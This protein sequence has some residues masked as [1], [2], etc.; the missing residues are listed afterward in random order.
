MTA[1]GLWSTHGLARA[2]AGRVPAHRLHGRT[3]AATILTAGQRPSPA[4]LPARASWRRCSCG[5][6]GRKPAASR[7]RCRDT[8]R[9]RARTPFPTAPCGSS[10]A[11]LPPT[12]A[13]APRCRNPTRA[14]SCSHHRRR[15]TGRIDGLPVCQCG[16]RCGDGVVRDPRGDATSAD[17]SLRLID[18]VAEDGT[19]VAF[20]SQTAYLDN[21]DG[22]V[23]DAT[24]GLP[25]RRFHDARLSELYIPAFPREPIRELGA[26]LDCPA[27][28]SPTAPRPG[29][30]DS[31]ARRRDSLRRAR[32]PSCAP[33]QASSSTT[34]CALTSWVMSYSR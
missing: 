22:V 15:S 26:M 30:A 23:T 9:S 14:A 13:V 31:D 6:G 32:H 2:S 8:L 10:S 1:N 17:L 28:P 27:A 3:G 25:R 5:A 7:P 34:L 29:A 18:F 16:A 24:P 12:P 19:G 20:P 11:T 4:P 21:G 33:S